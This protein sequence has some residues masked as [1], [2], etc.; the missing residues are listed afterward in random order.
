MP[1]RILKSS[2]DTT[3]VNVLCLTAYERSTGLMTRETPCTVQT[4]RK[5]RREKSDSSSL[6][7]S[8]RFYFLRGHN[9]YICIRSYVD[10]DSFSG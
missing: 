7:V 9:L 10:K 5:E 2:N 6:T 3:A 8:E 1:G 4:L